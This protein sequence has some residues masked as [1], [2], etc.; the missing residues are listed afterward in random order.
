MT[1]KESNIAP[2]EGIVVFINDHQIECLSGD[3]V[4]DN[5]TIP[6][7]F[8]LMSNKQWF[9]NMTNCTVKITELWVRT[10]EGSIPGLDNHKRSDVT[11]SKIVFELIPEDARI[12]LYTEAL[13]SKFRKFNRTKNKRNGT[14]KNI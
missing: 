9:A 12:T 4:K 5:V 7:V 11:I 6:T 1:V 8:L 3:V 10:T 14:N 2:P 13:P